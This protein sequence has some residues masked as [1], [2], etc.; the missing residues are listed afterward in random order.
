MS[1]EDTLY[2]EAGCNAQGAR[3]YMLSFRPNGS[4]DPTVYHGLGIS[5]IAYVSG[6]II[7][8]TMT[9]GGWVRILSYKWGFQSPASGPA[10]GFT[11]ELD[12]TNTSAD[13]GVLA[14]ALVNASGTRADIASDANTMAY[15][16]VVVSKEYGDS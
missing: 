8:I 16:E 3:R 7:K 5:A 2:D 11:I 6:S 14:F 13:N 10:Q 1:L 9:D 15:V 4:S 12:S